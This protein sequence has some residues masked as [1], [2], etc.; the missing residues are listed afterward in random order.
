[1]TGL[2]SDGFVCP[3]ADAHLAKV[4][5]RAG[6]VSEKPFVFSRKIEFKG[7]VVLVVR[8]EIRF[9]L[10]DGNAI[11]LFE[12]IR[13]PRHISARGSSFDEKGGDYL[14]LR[15]QSIQPMLPLGNCPCSTE[16]FYKLA[17]G[18]SWG[19]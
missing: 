1:M 5:V 15:L 4:E 6:R 12:E 8:W 14:I 10:A 11:S 7:S 16:V 13:N 2:L 19:S 17:R 18:S 9:A 3:F